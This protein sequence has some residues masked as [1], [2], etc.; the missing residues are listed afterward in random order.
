VDRAALIVLSMALGGCTTTRIQ[1]VDPIHPE[2]TMSLERTTFL[3]QGS[4]EMES[5]DGTWMRVKDDPISQQMAWLMAGLG[6]IGGA[7][8]GLPLGAAGSV[9]GCLGVGAA[10][11]GLAPD[12]PAAPP[13]EEAP[14]IVRPSERPLSWRIPDPTL[15]GPLARS[16]LVP[17]PPSWCL[18]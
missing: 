7:I 2:R 4:F 10:G 1:Y 8:A 6:C 14:P 5:P 3:R 13:I 17:T 15:T 9:I 16:C 18:P 12:E 11:A